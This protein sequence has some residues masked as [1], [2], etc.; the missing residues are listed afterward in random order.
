M[1]S[2]KLSPTPFLLCCWLLLA[3]H[4]AFAQSAPPVYVLPAVDKAIVV[5]GDTPPNVQGFQVYRKGPGERKFSL[6]T[7]QPVEPAVDPAVAAKLMGDDFQWIARKMDSIDPE[8]VWRK[9]RLDGNLAQ[10]YGLLSHGLRLAL[11]RTW[12]DT[13]TTP[14]RRYQYRVVL[15]DS[16]GAEIQRYERTIRIQDPELPPPP[17]EVTA[18]YEDGLVTIEWDYPPFRGGVDDR[19][20]GFVVFRRR[21]SGDFEPLGSAPAASSSTTRYW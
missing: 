14:G 6:L 3:G 1:R 21:G 7:P 8:V 2:P 4:P 12:I 17:R 5:L 10:A 13:G 20:V 16:A 18:T 11:G 19:T 15:L 9:L